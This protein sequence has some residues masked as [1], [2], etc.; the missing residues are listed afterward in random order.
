L[1]VIISVLSF[2]SSFDD[3]D[4]DDDNGIPGSFEEAL[5]CMDLVENEGSQGTDSQ[6]MNGQVNICYKRW[7]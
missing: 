5:A 6:E 4:D 7:Q 3:D 2:R 1:G